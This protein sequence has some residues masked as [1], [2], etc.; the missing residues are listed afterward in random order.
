MV[1]PGGA[2]ARTRRTKDSASA[3]KNNEN[4]F[5]FKARF[6]VNDIK[7]IEKLSVTPSNVHD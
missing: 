1:N 7:I 4:H 5:G 3:M 6:L 2:D